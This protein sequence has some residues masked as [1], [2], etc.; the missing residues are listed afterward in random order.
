MFCAVAHRRVDRT[1]AVI[2]VEQNVRL[3]Q[4]GTLSS[5]CCSFFARGAKNEQ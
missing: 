1:R 5:F 3:R 4:R 2:R